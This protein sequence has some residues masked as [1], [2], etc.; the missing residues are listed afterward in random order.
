MRLSRAVLEHE[1]LTSAVLPDFLPARNRDPDGPRQAG[2]PMIGLLDRNLRPR[3]D[4]ERVLVEPV[5]SG[6][7]MPVVQF[8]ESQQLADRLLAGIRAGREYDPVL[9]FM[10]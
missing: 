6:K 8:E 10:I 9:H 1:A 5:V 7:N 3:E 4:E 2:R